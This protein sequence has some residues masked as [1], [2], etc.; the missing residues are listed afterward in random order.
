[1]TIRVLDPRQPAEGDALRLAPAL[2]SLKGA[3]VGFIDNAKIG[4]ARL[5]DHLEDILRKKYG[6]RE[7]IR[8]RKP[9]AT[10]PAPAEILAQVSG[11]DAIISGIGD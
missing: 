2:P 8:R 7:F 4:T 10:R 1:M 6:V 3:A 5:Y 11:A 9:D